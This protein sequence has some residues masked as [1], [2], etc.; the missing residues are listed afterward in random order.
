MADVEL[1]PDLWRGKT[2]RYLRLPL[3]VQVANEP[4]AGEADPALGESQNLSQ[5]GILLRLPRAVAPR[6]PVRITMQLTHRDPLVLT[7]RVAWTR[8]HPDL[9]GWAVG[10]QFAEALPE[11][12]FLAIID[13]EPP[14]W[15]WAPWIEGPK[16]SGE[17]G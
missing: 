7:G 16:L 4:L 12:V 1:R 14:P 17:H 13:E 8:P 15:E 9:P 10:I 5:G 6:V 3:R 11:P 2:Q